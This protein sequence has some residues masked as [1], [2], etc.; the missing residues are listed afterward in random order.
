MYTFGCGNLDTSSLVT[1]QSITTEIINK[2]GGDTFTLSICWL[3]R[4]LLSYLHRF[5]LNECPCYYSVCEE[6]VENSEHISSHCPRFVDEHHQLV[7]GLYQTWTPGN[8]FE[9]MISSSEN[10]NVVSGFSTAISRGRRQ[11]IVRDSFNRRSTCCL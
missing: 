6:C 10:W 5:E 9:D 8:K 3:Y 2:I 7:E 1:S 11:L 4:N